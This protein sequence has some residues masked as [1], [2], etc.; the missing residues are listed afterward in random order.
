MRWPGGF[1]VQMRLTKAVQH[2]HRLRLD[3]GWVG[4]QDVRV[5]VALQGHLVT[6]LC[7]RLAQIHRPVQPQYLA[8]QLAHG[9]Q[10]Q[11][12]TFGKHQ[13][14]DDHAVMAAFELA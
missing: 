1:C 6:D 9:F 11:A 14:R 13:A 5:Q 7:T 8:V 3:L 12:A 4:E 10:P 2:L